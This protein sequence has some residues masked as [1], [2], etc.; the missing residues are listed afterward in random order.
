MKNIFI[1]LLAATEQ[2][3][4]TNRQQHI[5]TLTRSLVKQGKSETQFY[6]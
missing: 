5:Q 6:Y 4:N 3:N 1:H 2:C